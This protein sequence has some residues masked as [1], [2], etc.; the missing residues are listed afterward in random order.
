MTC[1]YVKNTPQ[2]GIGSWEFSQDAT[3]PIEYC[4]VPDNNQCFTSTRY[5]LMRHDV[6]F[7]WMNYF[8]LKQAWRQTFCPIEGG[9][10]RIAY[11]Y[12]LTKNL[13]KIIQ[14][15]SRSCTEFEYDQCVRPGTDGC[16]N[17]ERVKKEVCSERQPPPSRWTKALN[18]FRDFFSH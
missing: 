7:D 6:F 14:G 3:E 2:Q 18:R 13:V 4:S 11:R 16:A 8:F 10:D 12:A 5:I 9:D 15:E 1:V 17:I